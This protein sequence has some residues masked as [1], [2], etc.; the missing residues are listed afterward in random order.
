MDYFIPIVSGNALPYFKEVAEE[1]NYVII[2]YYEVYL[3]PEE[4]K[5]IKEVNP[6]IKTILS[7]IMPDE[8]LERPET[9]EYFVKY[10]EEV[11]FDYIL[12]WDL[13]TYL[14]DKEESWR[15]MRKSIEVIDGLRRRF[16]VIPL[17]KD[18]YPEQK[19]Y[20]CEELIEMGLE[21]AAIPGSPYLSVNEYI[22]DYLEKALEELSHWKRD[23][24][25]LIT[26]HIEQ[27]Y[28]DRGYKMATPGRWA[29][30][31]RLPQE[32]KPGAIHITQKGKSKQSNKKTHTKHAKRRR[33]R[34]WVKLHPTL[35]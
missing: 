3:L 35:K 33:D 11:G 19:R 32:I 15:N 28:I 23:E 8:Y 31:V 34:K 18:A 27:P 24:K 1:F 4:V 7:S 22:G 30:N 21:Y 16:K 6:Q 13:P 20:A 17:V 25:W 26:D 9:L 12:A 10:A 29:T 14:D 2:P 5:Q